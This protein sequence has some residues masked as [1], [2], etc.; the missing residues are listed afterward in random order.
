MVHDEYQYLQLITNVIINGEDIQ[1]RNGG[2]RMIFGTQM[3]FNLQENIIP[4]LTTKKLAWKTCLKELL[5]FIS[6]STS[7]TILKN[8]NVHIWDANGSKEFLESRGLNYEEDDLGPVYGHQWRH[9]NAPYN[10]CNT[11]YS[12][13]GV[14]QLNNVIKMLKDPKEKYSRRIILS[15]WNPCQLDEMA[16]PPCHVL[17]QF[18]VSKNDELSCILYQRSGD[19]GL[20]VPFNIASYSLLTHLLAHHC[21]LKPKEFIHFIGNAHIYSNHIKPLKE[22]I[23]RTPYEFPTLKISNKYTNIEDYKFEDFVIENYKSHNK[24]E[25]EMSA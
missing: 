12:N 24:I 2:T 22:Q 14:D 10:N 6:G 17:M 13:K 15:A 5:W 21:N 20:G 8:N 25:M 3:R 11:D 19:I 7:N 16:L 23:D 18:N 4:F 1:G 9:F